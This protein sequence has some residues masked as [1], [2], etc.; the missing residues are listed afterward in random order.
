MFHAKRC[1]F[2]EHHLLH[3][4]EFQ[5]LLTSACVYTI[6]VDS[7]LTKKFGA[8]QSAVEET[9]YPYPHPRLPEVPENYVSQYRSR[10]VAQ[11]MDEEE[12]EVEFNEM[13]DYSDQDIAYMPRVRLR[14]DVVGT[15]HPR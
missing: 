1:T 10:N 14:V 6:C 3:G 13:G 2:L 5:T 11:T 9:P 8:D 15:E 7:W 4:A 12:M